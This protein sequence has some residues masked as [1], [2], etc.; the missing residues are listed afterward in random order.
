MMDAAADRLGVR[1]DNND[2]FRAHKI[3][4]LQLITAV[5]TR[6]REVD[7]LCRLLNVEKVSPPGAAA[8]AHAA[9]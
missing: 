7:A 2:V 3:A 8:R 9:R 1:V 4:A 5:R 6:M